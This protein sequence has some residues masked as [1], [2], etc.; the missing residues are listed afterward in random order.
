MCAAWIVAYQKW[1]RLESFERGRPRLEQLHKEFADSEESIK[2][3]GWRVKR[4]FAIE[5]DRIDLLDQLDAERK[6][7]REKADRKAEEERKE[8]DGEHQRLQDA[9]E[10]PFWIA[11]G[12]TAFFLVSL[13]WR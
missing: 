13:A 7:Y 8:L 5:N 3:A 6:E 9:V 1:N 11:A 4:K 10:M 2:R 12:A